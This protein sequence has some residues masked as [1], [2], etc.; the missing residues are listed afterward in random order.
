MFGGGK[1][2]MKTKLVVLLGMLF[3]SSVFAGSQDFGCESIQASRTF[4]DRFTLKQIGAEE[5]R[6]GRAYDYWLRVYHGPSNEAVFSAKVQV[7]LAYEKLTI[8]SKKNARNFVAGTIYL[9]PG[10][11]DYNWLNYPRSR[12]PVKVK[13]QHLRSDIDDEDD[14]DMPRRRR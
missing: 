6:G 14:F 9:K 8:S 7:E 1:L 11:N 4:R 13:C 12:Q 10:A 2:K 5:L 3:S